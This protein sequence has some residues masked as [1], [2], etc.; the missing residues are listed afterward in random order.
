MKLTILDGNAVNPGDLSWSGFE[1]FAEV[2]VYPRTDKNDRIKRIGDS[3]AI[4]LNKVPIDK[5]IF[6][7]CPNLKYIGVLATGYNV[8][9]VEAARVHGVCVTNIPTYSTMAVA[10]H[11]FALLLH[12]ACLVAPHNE[13][14]QAGKWAAHPDFCYWDSPLTELYGK[15]FGILGY[16]NIGRAVARI[17]DAF[18]MKVLVVPHTRGS[19]AVGGN[20]TE[21]DFDSMIAR[22]NIISLHAPLTQETRLIINKDVIDK[23]KDDVYIINTARGGLVDEVAMRAALDSGK[24]AY[25][26]CDVLTDEPPKK[27]CP[28][29]GSPNAVITPH[30]AWA[31]LQTRQRLINIALLN[32]KSY[33]AGKNINVVNA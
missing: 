29:V 19:V 18:G 10:Q 30:N 24:V 7:A 25:Y 4:L 33:I 17:A 14:V 3:D 2:T 26:A 8:V 9:D 22:S 13:W 16:G 5:E 28:L 6:E 31:P 1:E 12:K 15:I 20:V 27:G 32:F 21:V 11:V 23:M